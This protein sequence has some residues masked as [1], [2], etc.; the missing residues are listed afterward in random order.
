L[1]LAL[2]ALTAVGCTGE[3]PGPRAMAALGDSITRAFA[4]CG[5]SGDCV[6]TSW[7]TGAARLRFGTSGELGE[8]AQDVV[9]LFQGVD[10]GARG[11]QRRSGGLRILDRFLDVGDP[12]CVEA[13]SDHPAPGV[14]IPDGRPT[15]ERQSQSLLR[16]LRGICE[17]SALPAQE[18]HQAG[19]GPP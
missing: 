8:Q 1:A 19:G 14:R 18:R 3:P 5:R 9:A 15:A 11:E 16:A 4:A 13:G 10:V 6:E 7:A 12:P 2:T 17:R